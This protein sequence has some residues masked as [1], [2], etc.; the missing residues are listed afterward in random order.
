MIFNRMKDKK[1]LVSNKT[2]Y[3]QLKVKEELI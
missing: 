1:T 2:Q 3:K